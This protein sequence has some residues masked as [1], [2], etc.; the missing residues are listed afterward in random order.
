M[1]THCSRMNSKCDSFGIWSTAKSYAE[2]T[3][4]VQSSQLGCQQVCDTLHPWYANF[5]I[6]SH[7]FLSIFR[8]HITNFYQ[9]QKS[10]LKL[11]PK[12]TILCNTENVK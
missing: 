5:V 2:N 12:L 6:N 4:L 1:Q 8:P 10:R 9:A 3:A 7:H 11:I